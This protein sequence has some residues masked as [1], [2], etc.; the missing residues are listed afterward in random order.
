[1]SEDNPTVIPQ[2]IDED[3]IIV[4]TDEDGNDGQFVFLTVLEHEGQDYALLAPL[5]QMQDESD[6]QLDVYVFGY[7]VNEEAEEFFEPIGDEALV[8]AIGAEAE[9]LFAELTA[10]EADDA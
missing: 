9:E 4:L 5:G 1:M 7:T 3:D 10:D 2:D 8:D 6:E